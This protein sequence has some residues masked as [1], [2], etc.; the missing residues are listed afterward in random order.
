[1]ML[2]GEIGR[3]KQ[4]IKQT[5]SGIPLK[6]IYSPEDIKD[7]EYEQDLNDAGS[8][9][10]TRGSHREMFI[11]RPWKQQVLCGEST[12]L[13]TNSRLQLLISAG[14]TGI[15]I[16]ADAPSILYLD[17]DHPLAAKTVGTQG[18]PLC[19]LQDYREVLNSIPLDSLTISWS[20]PNSFVIAALSALAEESAVN[21]NRI[22]GS[23]VL[24]DLYGED[25]GYAYLQPLD[26]RTRLRVDVVQYCAQHMPNFVSFLE[27]IYFVSEAGLD[28]IE[29]VTLGLIEMRYLINKILER[30]IS[31]DDFAHRIAIL[32]AV[33]MD[34]FEEIA[35]FRA[36]RRIWSRMMREDYKAKN[37]RSWC[38]TM[39]V[40]SSGLTLTSQQPANNII[41]G[42][43]Q[44]L[45]AILGGCQ[46]VEI[47]AFDEPYRTPT[48]ESAVLTLRTQQ[49]LAHET[50]VGNVV[51]PLG[52]SYYIECLTNEVEKRVVERIKEIEGQGDLATLVEAGYFRKFFDSTMNRYQRRLDTGLQKKVGVNIFSVPPEMDTMLKGAMETKVNVAEGQIKKIKMM[53]AARDMIGVKEALNF[54]H[55]TARARSANLIYAIKEALKK[56]ATI[57]EITGAIRLAYGASY[58]PHGMT[59]APF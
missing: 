27:D 9:P 28:V 42:A 19:C 47:C 12:P 55:K 38:P 18:V 37:P 45:A 16:V 5:E 44:A 11:S 15:D 50:G 43:Y 54:V 4:D 41:R 22:R 23:T 58:D 6:R 33:R 52:G 48:F 31:I 25:T 49:I 57:G 24:G 53:K 8:Y 35:K 21:L 3:M 7:L 59:V 14:Q 39:T 51:D 17:S 56:D 36:F 26:M 29:E 10:F 2:G 20:S 1:M 46:A 13:E 34:F 40:H 30:G 32:F